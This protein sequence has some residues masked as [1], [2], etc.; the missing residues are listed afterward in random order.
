VTTCEDPEFSSL[1]AY[2]R[3]QLARAAE[4]YASH[5]NIDARL[6]AVLEAVRED[7]HDN[8]AAADS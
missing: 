6:K 4:T 1:D 2:I 3:S 7:T 8:A 5:V